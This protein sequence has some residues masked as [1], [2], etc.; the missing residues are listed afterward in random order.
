MYQLL[1]VAAY[2]VYT[3]FSLRLLWHFL[4]WVRASHANR[5]V[6]RF[7]LSTSF[8][9]V[10]LMAIDLISFR[11]VMIASGPLWVGSLI[12]HLSFLL[13]SLGHLRYFTD[14][15]PAC[16]QDLQPLGLI[17]GY[18]LPASVI[19]LLSIRT[20]SVKHRYLTWHN[21]LILGLVLCIS[22]GGLLLRTVFRTD[23]VAIKSFAYG[24]L[25]LQPALLQD[26]YLFALHFALVL[27]LVLILPSHIFSAPLIIMEAR[28]RE[29]ELRM[30]MHDR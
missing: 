8:N 23:L 11:R 3:V 22:T 1:A 9:T 12:F 20:L 21:Y 18:L 5:G 28:R 25:T 29:Q 14:P 6:F 7:K 4:I 2:I 15:V 27:I 26:A 30:V 24:L 19:W 16:I 10:L 17:A 13:V